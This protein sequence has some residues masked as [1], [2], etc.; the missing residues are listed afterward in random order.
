MRRWGSR[1]RSDWSVGDQQALL[2]KRAAGIRFEVLFE[3]QRLKLAREG[4]IPHQFP[5][6]V[7]SGVRRLAGVVVGY[8]VFQV[9]GR[10]CVF[11]VRKV[12]ASDDV[13]V[14]HC[15]PSLALPYGSCRT[16]LAFG[17]YR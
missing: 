16:S 12:D 7:L 17:R 6:L 14:P 11:L 1:G 5:Q 9:L 15:C 10:A 2:C 8:A 13:D 4:A 3:F